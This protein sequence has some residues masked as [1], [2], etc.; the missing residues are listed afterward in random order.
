MPGND[1]FQMNAGAVS[2]SATGAVV[3]NV[4]LAIMII[5]ASIFVVYT[6]NQQTILL[7]QQHDALQTQL[8][9][10]AALVV[11]LTRANEN[12]FL[13]TMLPNERKKELPSYI[14]DRAREIV[15]RRAENITETRENEKTRRTP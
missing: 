7:T 13:S 11:N 3:V 4:L 8:A 15:E 9:S 14:Q 12:V 1:G 2:A 6:T 10:N 5:I